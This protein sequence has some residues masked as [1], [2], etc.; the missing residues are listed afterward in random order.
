MKR[1][2]SAF[3]L[4]TFIFISVF[5]LNLGMMYKNGKMT[6]CPLDNSS[7]ICQMNVGSHIAKWQQMFQAFPSTTVSLFFLLGFFFIAPVFYVGTRFSLAPPTSHRLKFYQNK[8]RDILFDKL[9][10]AFSDGI[11]HSKIYV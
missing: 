8:Q 9:L 11:L 2:F 3:I 5:G 4:I 1:I 7:S 6:N 10:L